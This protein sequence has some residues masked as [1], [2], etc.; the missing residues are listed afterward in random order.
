MLRSCPTVQI[1]RRILLVAILG[2]AALLVVRRL[3]DR[4]VIVHSSAGVT[5]A[6]TDRLPTVARRP[7]P[8]SPGFEG[9]PAVGD[10]GDRELNQLKNRVDTAAWVPTPFASV[11]GLGW[12]PGVVRRMRVNWTRGDAR[13]VAGSE[14]LPVTVEGYFVA[15]KVE[16]PEST[17]CHGAESKFRDWHLWLASSPGK[18]RR[19]S[20]VVETTPV[21]RARHPEWS[22]GDI[23]RLVRDSTLVRISGWLLFDPDHPEQLGKTRGTLWEIHPVMRIE[24]QRDGQWVGIN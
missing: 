12:P 16:G 15:A 22:L 3:S 7:V 11:L 10:G 1:V 4:A 5:P 6:R 8:E 20:I 17:N 23:R 14:G 24:I 2:L 13:R 9:C 21:I 19:R 18:D